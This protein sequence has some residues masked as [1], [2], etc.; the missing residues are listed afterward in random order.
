MNKLM[1][2]LM[3]EDCKKEK[4]STEHIV[5]LIGDEVT[6]SVDRTRE[7]CPHLD[8]R[9]GHGDL[10]CLHCGEY[11]PMGKCLPL[12]VDMVSVI[13]KEF[14]RKHRKCKEGKKASWVVS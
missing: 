10:A 3:R 11:F 2:I 1:G 4:N 8:I 5:Y 9:A 7:K 14:I 13:S 6:G 12:G